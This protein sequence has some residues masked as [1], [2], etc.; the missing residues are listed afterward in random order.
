MIAWLWKRQRA[1]VEAARQQA[2]EATRGRRAAEARSERA[3]RIVQYSRK[4]SAG[5][6][7]ELDANGD[8][9]TALMQQAW[10]GR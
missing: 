10:G 5:L 1:E 6:Q 3:E 4:V 9:W 8:R 7:R 2:E